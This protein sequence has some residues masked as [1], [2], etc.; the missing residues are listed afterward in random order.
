MYH[1]I[2]GIPACIMIL[3]LLAVVIAIVTSVL[4]RGLSRQLG[5]GSPEYRLPLTL[6]YFLLSLSS[7]SLPF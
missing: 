7:T 2:V 5:T 6:F 4:Y 1:I 3:T